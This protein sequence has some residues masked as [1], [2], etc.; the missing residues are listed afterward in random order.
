M[1]VISQ[2]Y[3][4]TANRVRALNIDDANTLL[5]LAPSQSRYSSYSYVYYAA[6]RIFLSFFLSLEPAGK[7]ALRVRGELKADLVL[8]PPFN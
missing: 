8:L 6:S 1:S 3:L 2:Y 5:G 7:Y 4:W